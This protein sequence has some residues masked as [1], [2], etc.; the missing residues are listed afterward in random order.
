[1]GLISR[2]S[3][4]TYRQFLDFYIYFNPV[5]STKMSSKSYHA[6]SNPACVI[7]VGTGFTKLGYSGNQEPQFI[8]ESAMAIKELPQAT[9][10]R[11]YTD[12]HDLDF[13]VGKEALN[14]PTPYATKSPLRH[15]Q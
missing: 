8:I 10:T 9:T 3:S 1:M 14:K 7:D 6:K 12:L 15:G 11:V 4:R 5:S 2:V 13:F